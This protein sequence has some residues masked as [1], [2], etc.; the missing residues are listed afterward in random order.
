MWW[1][2][3]IQRNYFYCSQWSRDMRSCV[4]HPLRQTTLASNFSPSFPSLT[5]V[6][7]SCKVAPV[8]WR[9]TFL[10]WVVERMRNSVYTKD[11]IEN[12][13][14]GKLYLVSQFSYILFSVYLHIISGMI[15]KTY[16][17]SIANNTTFLSLEIPYRNHRGLHFKCW[18]TKHLWLHYF[19]YY[20]KIINN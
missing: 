12:I 5:T 11:S 14:T 20:Y 19:Y 15:Y 7:F 4:T 6:T 3:H 8:E 2:T 13:C 16:S 18:K 9:R 1:T 10:K 17:L